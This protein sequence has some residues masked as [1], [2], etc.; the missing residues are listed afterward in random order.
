MALSVEEIGK[1]R[2]AG[3]SDDDI[4]SYNNELAAQTAAPAPVDPNAPPAGQLPKY[5]ETDI[6][7]TAPPPEATITQG[8]MS[9]VPVVQ[10]AIPYAIGGAAGGAVG[11]AGKKAI[12]AMV[13]RGAPPATPPAAPVAP[14]TAPAG[15]RIQVPQSAGSGPRPIAPTP[16]APAPLV[17]E[18][19]G[20]RNMPMPEPN[21]INGG[22]TYLQRMAVLAESV[23]PTL[24]RV[25]GAAGALLMPGNIGQQ[26][27]EEEEIRK[28]RAKAK[29]K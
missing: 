4:V 10:Q 27:D 22:N 2:E 19:V 29:V 11:I 18:S 8:V 16:G 28:R 6:P 12:E 13:A 3:F 21:P 23:A 26:I 1:L 15:P 7:V 20:M 24:G 14:Q 9:A 25:G 17:R 5:S